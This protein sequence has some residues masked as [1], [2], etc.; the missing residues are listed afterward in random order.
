MEDQRKTFIDNAAIAKAIERYKKKEPSPTFSQYKNVCFL[1]IMGFRSMV[2]STDL[3]KCPYTGTIP[4]LLWIKS[5]GAAVKNVINRYRSVDGETKIKFLIISD[6]FYLFFNDGEIEKVQLLIG[7]IYFLSLKSGIYIRGAI[8][9]AAMI[10]LPNEMDSMFIG[11]GIIES[12][13]METSISRFSRIVVSSHLIFSNY[14]SADD[15]GVYVFRVF[16]FLR[17]NYSSILQLFSYFDDKVGS[18]DKCQDCS[19]ALE[20]HCLLQ[21]FSTHFLSF[22]EEMER[23]KKNI[24][25]NKIK[26][27]SSISGEK[28]YLEDMAIYM[29]YCELEKEIEKE[30]G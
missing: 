24:L 21:S 26:F 19:I 25:S 3:N 13:E 12:Y 9:S 28:K 11:K 29:K 17:E 16:K 7:L 22:D 6:S 27:S 2:F 30:E 1:D 4:I 20:N 8:S 18:L 5:L 14:L 10:S 15:D 23:I